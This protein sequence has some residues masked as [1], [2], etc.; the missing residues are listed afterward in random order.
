MKYLKTFITAISLYLLGACSTTK[1]DNITP[2][3]PTYSI[4]GMWELSEQPEIKDL[5]THY[6]EGIP[7]ISIS[8]ENNTINGYD[9]CNRFSTTIKMNKNN[10]H[11]ISDI[12]STMIWC[13]KVNTQNFHEILKQ[14][15][16][17]EATQHT[18]T[19]HSPIGSLKFY[20]I[21]L[22]GRWFLSKI[23]TVKPTVKELYPY[24]TP[25]IDLN[26]NSTQFSGYT[27]C[28]AIKGQILIFENKMTFNHVSS[29]EK[30]CDDTNDNILMQ[31][32]TKVSNYKL[33]GTKLILFEKD[34]K[35][36]ELERKAP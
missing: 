21:A 11:Q 32:L 26:I 34:K 23:Y 13:E 17:H 4:Y 33:E 7:T 35:I 16:S 24:K 25:F 27:A 30:Y 6:A 1:K 9:G 31:S 36:L 22:E 20:R 14:S 3:I 18:L 19:I 15:T 12:I 29:T 10:K 8:Q 2:P 5:K 28:N